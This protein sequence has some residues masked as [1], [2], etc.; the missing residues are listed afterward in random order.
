VNHLGV[1][2]NLLLV[3]TAS[4]AG[5]PVDSNRVFQANDCLAL[6][7]QSNYDGYFYLLNQGSSGKWKVLLPSPDMVEELNSIQART[8]VQAP[9]G[10]CFTP[11][12]PPGVE[13]LFL[14]VARSPQDAVHLNAAVK[15]VLAGESD[16]QSKS[17][18]SQQ[19]T[20]PDIGAEMARLEQ[21]MKSRELRI[22]KI[23]KPTIAGEPA[24]AVYVVDNTASPS[25]RIAVE[26]E[27]RHK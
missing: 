11:D 5:Q 24:N 3:D 23:G 12:D 15:S 25:D 13:H 19:A 9:S 22:T 8:S 27:I 26:I 4:G 20:G 6:S 18:A 10:Y 21:G 17:G 2:Y 7:V 1:R 16:N 14:V